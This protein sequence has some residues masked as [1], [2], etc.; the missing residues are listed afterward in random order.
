MK[1]KLL[2]LLLFF[3][4]IA[5][6]QQIDDNQIQRLCSNLE[7]DEHNERIIEIA[8]RFLNKPYLAG[9]LE[10]PKEKLMC[11][12][13]GF[14]CYT[15]VETV[16]ALSIISE[17]EAP[18]K[19]DFLNEMQSLRYR[20]G[21]I[22]DY[23]SRIHYFFEWAKLAES[24]G[25]LTDMSPVLGVP[26][27]K[28]INFMSSHRQYYPA[29][30]TDNTALAKIASIEKAVNKYKFHEIKKNDLPKVESQIKN[31]DI[32]AFASTI[33]G[34]DVNH[35]G[36]AYWKGDKLHFI[37]A[38]SEEM[39]VVISDETLQAYINRIKKHSGLMVLRVI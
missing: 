39:K 34:L 5:F 4:T 14:D 18:T 6:A 28:A 29:L 21:E 7:S 2:S 38:S 26:S 13:D 9:S 36:I 30:K 33:G 35:E 25:L 12:L 16:L 20:N 19:A 1:I 27:P 31:G 23:S 32:I 10:S 17:V 11:R 24:K 15:F 3:S 8:K 37:H 22:T